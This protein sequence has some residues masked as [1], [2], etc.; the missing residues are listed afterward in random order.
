MFGKLTL[1][2]AYSAVLST[3]GNPAFRE[4]LD[5]VEGKEW[6]SRDYRDKKLF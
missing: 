5:T 2:G 4:L 3:E 1:C 6:E